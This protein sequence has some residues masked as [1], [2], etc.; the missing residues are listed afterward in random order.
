MDAVRLLF[1][2]QC[3]QSSSSL[4]GI[5][6]YSLCL[7]RALV[8]GAGEHQ[9]EVL[10]NGGD[11]PDR[12]LRARAA[13]ET[14]LPPG[15][16]H[17]FD[18][19]WPWHH[20]DRQ[21]RRPGA[22]AAYAGAVSS[23]RPD[24]L[25]V[26]SV[27]EGDGEN[28]L[29]V[30]TGPG[31]VPTAAL[32]YDLIPAEDP[33]TYLLGP[34]GDEYW[35]RFEELRRTD[36]LL[37]ISD[38][39]AGQARRL[40]GSQAPPIKTVLGGPYPSGD[41][42][43]FEPQADAQPGMN[44]PP[45]FLLSVGG[46]HP[47]KNM[48]G[49]VQA[50]AAV[51]A[52]ARAG[53]ALVLACGL[54]PGTVRRLH[55]LARRAGLAPDEL[56]LTGRVSERRLH[57]LYQQAIAFVFPSTQE[58]LGM[59]PIEAM[60][61]GRAT[62]LARSSSLVEL[63]DD[64]E[65][66]FDGDDI[67]DMSRTLRRLLADEPYRVRLERAAGRSAQRLTWQRAAQR[68]WQALTSLTG[69]VETGGGRP[70][71]CSPVADLDAAPAPVQLDARLLA[72]PPLPTGANR[73]VVVQDE[74]VLQ[75][76]STSAPGLRTALAAATALV[77]EDDAVRTAAVGAGLIE[78]PLLTA[79]QLPQA[80]LHDLY[81]AMRPH[82]AV[83]RLRT[84]QTE[85]LVEAVEIPPRWMLERPRPVWLVLSSSWR[86]P[87]LVQQ[88]RAAADDAGGDL[89]V[90]GPGGWGLARSADVVAAEQALLAEVPLR[91]ARCRGTVVVALREPGHASRSL[92]PWCQ[93]AVLTGPA[94]SPA[95]WTPVFRSWA[96]SWGRTTGWPWRTAESAAAG[97]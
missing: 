14:F 17:V 82:L 66:F 37:S 26:G 65:A 77:T 40:L 29:R 10:L 85:A 20:T 52:S 94:T 41:F 7:L 59:P 89:L 80:G 58:G 71:V 96:T 69:E 12:L 32:L 9:V 97:S 73:D 44:L 79:G 34:G 55:R 88:M 21:E 13:L 54:N 50:W 39:S 2:A 72:G 19:D 35:R 31:H 86:D 62:A 60:A 27:F 63:A 16:I 38:Y 75:I 4:R 8:Q 84:A 24:V 68:A 74:S 61:A 76:V 46:D 15:R 48:D 3:I 11:D 36:L 30:T 93:Q 49:L 92:P 22:E 67:D 78:H 53:V 6:R 45:L 1:D 64:D 5:G 95:S 42:P 91:S 56:V 25:L 23:L 51:P 81:A 18:A 87:D 83:A 47:R 28:V 57:D 90:A 33:G 70:S 43:A